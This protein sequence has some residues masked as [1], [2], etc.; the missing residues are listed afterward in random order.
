MSKFWN[1]S[2]RALSP[3]VP[4][5]QPKD[6]QKLIKLNTNECP[7]PPSPKVISAICNAADSKLRLY[8]NADGL[9]ARSAFAKRNGLAVDQVFVGNGSDEVLAI[10]FQA[11][12]GEEAIFLPQISYSFYPVYCQL[13]GIDSVAVPMKDD[14]SVDVDAFCEQELNGKICGGVAIANPNAPTTKALSLDDIARILEAHPEKV[15]LIDEAYVDFGA[16]SAISLIDRYPN[17]LVV[18]TL[19]KSRA[20]A[21][22]RVGFAAGS[23]ELIEGM[24]RVKNCFNSYTLDRLAIAGAA[25]AME[26]EEYFLETRAKIIATRERIAA[27]LRNMGFDLPDSSA[28]FLFATHP[29]YDAEKLFLF[30]KSKNILVRY[31]SSPLLCKH[32][33]ISIGTDEEMDE[34]IRAIEEYMAK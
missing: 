18:Q 17:L 19:S 12:F 13:Y 26:D 27:K 25:A 30:L 5:E 21:G 32:L 31:F 28:N 7:Y 34:L 14:F 24:D 33:R 3:Y 29:N 15:V 6:G 1:S 16:E 10:A 22:L 4:G 9:D 8:P 11:F 2:T 20:L 23:K